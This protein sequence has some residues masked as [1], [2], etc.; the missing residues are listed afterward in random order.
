MAMLRPILRINQKP[1]ESR[2]IRAAVTTYLN[3]HFDGERRKHRE[4]NSL[5]RWRI[6][7]DSYAK[8]ALVHDAADPAEYCFQNLIR[9][10]DEEARSGIWLE[11]PAGFAANIRR[12][13][14]EPELSGQLYAEL[15]DMFG[16]IFRNDNWYATQNVEQARAVIETRYLD[17]NVNAEL[18][19]LI[20]MFHVSNEDEATELVDD[21]RA[22]FYTY[23]EN[24]ARH[25]CGLSGTLSDIA[26]TDLGFTISTLRQRAGC[27]V[28]R[29]SDIRKH[30][31]VVC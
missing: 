6:S 26:S 29:M 8:L 15:P 2:K 16:H 25:R 21:L 1:Q 14:G 28:S 17:A 4:I 23:H 3:D 5:R 24:E 11:Q 12:L 27:Y 7:T 30:S 9:E 10:I 13:F 18:S 22:S 31:A 19:E 20:L